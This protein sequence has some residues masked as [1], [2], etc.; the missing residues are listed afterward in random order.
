MEP[1]NHTRATRVGIANNVRRALVAGAVLPDTNPVCK[2]RLKTPACFPLHPIK[3]KQRV[4]ARAAFLRTLGCLFYPPTQAAPERHTFCAR[5]IR[6]Q[7][8]H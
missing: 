8:A 2:P 5:L 1:D 7:G 6:R 4:V 3:A